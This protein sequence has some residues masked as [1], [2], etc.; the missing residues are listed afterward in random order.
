MISA[1]IIA[2][3]R[4]TRVP[5]SDG[6]VAMG[7]VT[8]PKTNRRFDLLAIHAWQSGRREAHG[9][10]VKVSRADWLR[11]AADPA[12]SAPLMARCNRYWLVCPPDVC[13]KTEVP[14]SWGLLHVYDDQIRQAK[15]APELSPEPWDDA[16]WRCM[17]LRCA[18]RTTANAEL[19]LAYENGRKDGA[20][21]A[22]GRENRELNQLRLEN[23][24]LSARAKE[25]AELTGVEL[26]RWAHDTELRAVAAVA[27]KLVR[28]PRDARASHLTNL[29]SWAQ[30]INATLTEAAAAL[31]TFGAENEPR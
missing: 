8:P 16:M 29:A 24:R 17:L 7:E 12:K 31:S 15:P 20:D 9:F 28:M 2:R 26:D 5:L 22:K 3:L 6:W 25:F 21:E 13:A 10:E 18:T 11:E 1:D 27:L 30:R 4:A 23:E 14:E 19:S